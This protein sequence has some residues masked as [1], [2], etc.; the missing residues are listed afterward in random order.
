MCKDNLYTSIGLA[1]LPLHH[2]FNKAVSVMVVHRKQSCPIVFR[3]ITIWAHISIWPK[4]VCKKFV[5]FFYRNP[6]PAIHLYHYFLCILSS[7]MSQLNVSYKSSLLMSNTENLVLGLSGSLISSTQ[8]LI[9]RSLIMVLHTA[10][11]AV[12]VRATNGSLLFKIDLSS[13]LWP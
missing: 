2:L 3:L 8:F 6:F 9:E 1:D 10:S 7:V 4:C 11:V 13:D 5:Q 12:A